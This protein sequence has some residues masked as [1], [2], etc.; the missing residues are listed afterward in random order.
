MKRRVPIGLI[1]VVAYMGRMQLYTR[2]ILF[3]IFALLQLNLYG[4]LKVTDAEI[5]PYSP[6]NLISNI[7]LGNGV[8][9]INIQ[10]EGADYSVGY[11]ENAT[12]QID[13]ER[14]I[15]MTTGRADFA[16]E[17]NNKSNTSSHSSANNLSD[18]NLAKAIELDPNTPV[19]LK[20]ISRYTISFI[21]YADSLSFNYVFASEEYPEYA[22]SKYKDVFGFFVSGPDPKGG[23]Y[24]AK[25]I[26]LIPGTGE[27]VSISNVNG[28]D[29]TTPFCYPKN[30]QFYNDNSD[31]L[32]LTYNAYLDV[33][34]AGVKVI[35]CQEYTISIAIADV[36][37]GLYDSAVFLEAKS[38]S[39]NGIEVRLDTPTPDHK[40]AEGCKEA[41]INFSF[42]EAR[43]SDFEINYKL[44]NAYA[45]YPMASRNQDYSGIPEKIILPAGQKSVEVPIQAIQDGMIEEDEFI[46][47]E[48][49]KNTCQLDTIFL[50]II[51]Q[52]IPDILLPDS[53]EICT[54]DSI[55]IE[56][57]LSEGFQFPG[58]TSYQ[59]SNDLVIS[60]INTPVFSNIHISGINAPYLS[61]GVIEKVCID[62]AWNSNLEDFDFFLYTPGGQFIELS[63]DNGKRTFGGAVIDSFV[64]T[65]FT[66]TAAQKIHLGNSET[67]L[68]NPTNPSYT[69]NYLP[70]GIWSD[71]W[72]DDEQPVNGIWRL[73]IIDDAHSFVGRLESWSITLNSEYGLH[74]TWQTVDNNISCL[75]CDDPVV[76]P[77][78]NSGYD[79][80]TTDSYG[81][82]SEDSTFVSVIQIP[83]LDLVTCDSVSTDMIQFSWTPVEDLPMYEYEVNGSGNW[84]ETNQTVVNFSGLNFDEE[85]FISVRTKDEKCKGD[86]K[87]ASCRTYPCPAPDFTIE[88]IQN[89]ACFGDASGSIV[90]S[91]SGN[92][93]AFM[94]ELNG[95]TNNTGVFSNLSGGADTLYI[96]DSESCRIPVEFNISAPPK[97]NFNI[98]IENITCHDTND[99]KLSAE[100][101]GGTGQLNYY[102]LDGN[103]I[104]LGND[105]LT[106]LNPGFYSLFATD[107]NGCKRDTMV[108]ISYPEPINI[109]INTTPVACK[110]ESSG[111]ISISTSGGYGGFEYSWTN[112]SGIQ[113]EVEDLYGIEGGIYFL[114]IKD[115]GG[116]NLDTMVQ[117]EAP[118][119]ALSYQ[120]EIKD[121][122][123]QNAADGFIHLSLSGGT[124]NKTIEWNTGDNDLELN[125]LTAGLYGFIINDENGCELIDR[126]EL[127][128]LKPISIETKN[129]DPSCFDSNDGI[130]EVTE[131]SYGEKNANS[132]D[133]SFS[134][135][136]NPVQY[137]KKAQHL[138]GPRT[139]K[140]II[141][142]KYACQYEKSVF[143]ESPDSIKTVW[144]QKTDPSCFGYDNGS[145]AVHATGGIAPYTYRWST[146]PETDS[147]SIINGLDAGFYVLSITDNNECRAA[148]TYVVQNPEP[149]STTA[150]IKKVNCYEGQDGEIEL[151][152]SGGTPPYNFTWSDGQFNN[153][154]NNLASGPV[155]V[156]ITDRKMCVLE[157]EFEVK[158]PISRLEAYGEST[159]PICFGEQSGEVI[160]FAEGGTKPYAYQIGD[161]YFQGTNSFI[162]VL[163]GNYMASVTDAND[164]EMEIGPI[165]V[166]EGNKIQVSIGQDTILNFG[167]R[168]ELE[169]FISSENSFYFDYFWESTDPAGLSCSNCDRTISSSEVPS[170]VSLKVTDE[171]DCL[172]QDIKYIGIQL[173]KFM[174][175][176]SA[177]TPNGDGIN[178]LLQVF[179]SPGSL[180]KQ[181]NIFDR[182]GHIIYTNSDFQINDSDLGWD[183][184]Y[185]GQNMV[186][187]VYTW[188]AEVEHIDHTIIIYKGQTS[189][190]R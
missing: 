25:N 158:Q 55:Q 79:L 103:G 136:T 155:S 5:N 163:A 152:V 138:T 38:F 183:G 89:P 6:V 184:R 120:F 133:F 60:P 28:G 75:D 100:I 82:I 112:P 69:G 13:L 56:T 127:I 85:I 71:L 174:N 166:G 111:S 148:F 90:L 115:A 72:P 74:Y 42:D 118:D 63:T 141:E 23:L 182:S 162:G 64:N 102:W 134:W 92:N 66:E 179:G 19:L 147:D 116:C 49:Q 178:D 143:L 104:A 27:S 76:F 187:D 51:D 20:D 160:I 35:P 119:A 175:V 151:S 113:S 39:T 15:I 37:D 167:E 29:D 16:D 22:C 107:E 18:V 137:N 62:T 96:I 54:G 165:M 109:I 123:C 168:I 108:S 129:T 68:M 33:F 170:Y 67:G 186:S 81:C 80:I 161:R 43:P 1:R 87:T 24:N 164:C 10:Y 59:N 2:L 57:S 126:F 97:I 128:E 48:Y 157:A 122:L 172:G 144:S 121:T 34:T 110:G 101:S 84:I 185:N 189:L 176:P 30:G 188:Y 88:N 9:I 11:F 117:V 154:A 150:S 99:G 132:S 146:D 180:V 40:I 95:L 31:D 21:P 142:D 45:G 149:I 98:E 46:I 94:F 181:F 131:I 44:L 65:C 3:I 114:T 171:N 124:G 173:D 140:L 53:L 7:F 26:A 159:D 153:P 139:Y 52:I 4:Q 83:S 70:E 61:E 50:T 125:D 145:I 36:A 8:E 105:L 190:L 17:P 130:I 58:P 135:L 41:F 77:L 86:I 47:I 169:P 78:Q 91:V 73:M 156:K 14:G 93:E 177:F 106:D 32:Y 12:A